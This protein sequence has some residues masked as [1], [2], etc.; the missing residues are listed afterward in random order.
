MFSSRP[1]LAFYGEY[2]QDFDIDQL[3][4]TDARWDVNQNYGFVPV[5][6][7]IL[8]INSGDPH[9]F[10]FLIGDFN[11]LFNDDF[12][13][14]ILFRLPAGAVSQGAG[15]VVSDVA[16]SNGQPDSDSYK[17]LWI[18]PR[19]NGNIAVADRMCA[20]NESPCSY[21][22][23]IHPDITNIQDYHSFRVIYSLGQYSY[24]IDEELIIKTKIGDPLLRFLWI[25]NTATNL[26]NPQ[27]WPV[28]NIDYIHI[29]YSG[30]DFL[31]VPDYKQYDPA[32]KDEEYDHASSWVQATTNTIEHW[33]CALSSAAMVLKYHGWDVNPSTL[34]TWL[35]TQADGF[36]RNGLINWLAV[37]RY[38]RVSGPA[39]GFDALEY[40]RYP[41]FNEAQ[42]DIELAALRPVIL[43]EPGHFVVAKGKS[44][45]SYAINDP[46]YS[47]RPTLASYSD[48]FSSLGSFIPSNTD[49][50]YIMLVINPEISVEI[51]DSNGDP[52]S[53]TD[54]L[55]E[56]IDNPFS[57]EDSGETVRIVL[58]PKP[59]DGSYQLFL[60]GDGEYSL[61]WYL[62]DEQGEENAGT[63][64]GEVNNDTDEFL[65]SIVDGEVIE[66]TSNGNG[67]CLNVPGSQKDNDGSNGFSLSAPAGFYVSGLAIKSGNY[68]FPSPDGNS[69]S[70]NG[71]YEPDLNGPNNCYQV[72]GIGTTNASAVKVGNGAAQVCQNISHIEIEVE[73]L[74]TIV[75][76]KNSINDSSQEFNFHNNF[77]NGHPDTFTLA[78]DSTPGLPSQSFQI[79]PGTYSVSEDQVPG[80]QQESVNCSGGKNENSINV[81]SGETVTCTFT[82]EQFA[83]IVLIKNTIGGDGSF[84]FTFT[85]QGL[86]ENGQTL[87]TENGTKEVIFENLDQDNTYS[88]AEIVPEGW[89][90][91]SSTCSADTPGNITPNAGQTI[92]C[93]FTNSKLP[94]LT[95]EKTVI[96]NNGG[97]ATKADFQGFI[98]G[99]E[100]E[101]D[102]AYTLQPGSY[103]ATESDFPNYQPSFWGTDCAEDGTLTLAYGDNKVCSIT[104]DDVP[105]SLTLVKE[106]INDNGGTAVNIDWVL[107]ADGPISISG[108]G[109]AASDS[110]FSA[111]G[112]I[113]S[114]S[115]GPAGYQASSWVCK[116]AIQQDNQITLGLGDSVICTITNDDIT[117]TLTVTKILEPADDNGLFDLQIDVV[118]EKTDA[119]NGGTTNQT[120]VN[121]GDHSVSE[122]AG[123]NTNLSEYDA[124]IGGDCSP[125]GSVTLALAENKTCTITNTRHGH[126][127]VDKNTD[128]IADPTEFPV[129]ISGGI[130]HGATESTVTDAIDADFEV[131][132]GTFSVTENTPS[133]WQE[134]SNTCTDLE[135]SAGETVTCEITNVKLGSI[136]IIKDAQPNDEQDFEFNDGTLG[137][138]TLDDDGGL[139]LSGS[140]FENNRLFADLLPGTYSFTE[141]LPNE[142]WT[143]DSI[144]C[145]NLDSQAAF[146]PEGIE[147]GVEIDLL[148]GMNISCTFVNTKP[149][150][151]RTHGFW[152]TH[153][154]FT[155]TQFET[156]FDPIGMLVGTV[157]SGHNGYIHNLSESGKSELFG[158]YFANIAKKSTSNG[159][160]AQ[161]AQVDKVR[162]QLLQQLVTAKLNCETFGC[163]SSVETTISNADSAYA[164][165][166]IP[167]MLISLTELD[168]YNNSG[169][170]LAIEN[171][172]HATPSISKSYAN[173][174]FWNQP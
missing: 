114:E 80:W 94:T 34:N 110:T 83:K 60:S 32:W 158:A 101:W 111:G 52:V 47:D 59:T 65:I 102:T 56:P 62:Y 106:V 92:T 6:G 19:T 136:T 42:L 172:G 20:E 13:L 156:H 144:S 81:V 168:D 39:N 167:A 159:K 67:N 164:A 138:F 137:S 55:Q 135:V 118:T 139:G 120:E 77:G 105:P 54:Y 148:A 72:S 27:T 169:D 129:I 121:A 86:P 153:T 170:T 71:T 63:I 128:P 163:Q 113:L 68:C 99:T 107:T 78:D 93:T 112:Y 21:N 145:L 173:I 36:I 96:T 122:V 130:I 35:K 64:G 8:T 7:D 100:A 14:E 11:D 104:N 115:P 123:T 15:I 174:P 43:A 79:P 4:F 134:T 3:V 1:G 162:M 53:I 44:D 51:Q 22:T 146:I 82:N 141:N 171:L 74:A 76:E 126:V 157:A 50:S 103:T 16:P 37:S 18:W 85:G 61:D 95:L 161:R 151:T 140:E 29:N 38:T 165:G 154:D 143:Q 150:P 48:T 90:L 5:S 24:Y 12:E 127:I 108:N 142:F 69:Y 23:N 97:T 119:G 124:V 73:E 87:T 91:T 31:N 25:G 117:P 147:N 2:V 155:S 70:Q 75:I 89:E 45:T 58:I 46:G 160:T 9:N 30:S 132:P 125:D 131:S 149:S 40:T 41:G 57:T 84:D 152:Q 98:N 133:G 66:D 49:L 26:S 10:P 109:G 28:I 166:D 33:G 88:I 116:G 17:R